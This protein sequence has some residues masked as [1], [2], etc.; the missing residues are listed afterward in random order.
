MAWKICGVLVAVSGIAMAIAGTQSG[1]V[2]AGGISCIALIVLGVFMFRKGTPEGKV[3]AQEKATLKAQ[4]AQKK[5]DE[6]EAWVRGIDAAHMDGLPLSEGAPCSLTY[7]ETALH[8]KGGGNTFNLALHKI[9]DIDIKTDVEIQKAYI[10]SAGGALGGAMLFGALG[11][12]IGGRVKEKTT[13]S[14]EN[15]LIVTYT[16]EEKVNYMSFKIPDVYRARQFMQLVQKRIGDA[17]RTIN[18]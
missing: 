7:E 6:I 10:S 2:V 17:G 3:R 8:I 5:R 12:I 18:L 13:R 14:C 11:A 9:T 15:Y 4:R 16:A 1:D